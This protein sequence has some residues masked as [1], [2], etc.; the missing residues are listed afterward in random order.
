MQNKVVIGCLY[1]TIHG[2]F[3]S[4]VL[5]LVCSTAW[6][7]TLQGTAM[8]RERIALPPDAVFEAELQ[9]VSRAGAPAV[10]LGRYTL[11]PAGQPPFLF[12]I[13]YDDAAVQPGHRYTVRAIVKHQE[14]LLFTTDTHYP[15]LDGGNK[16]LQ[17]LLVS[18]RSGAKAK[19]VPGGLGSLPASYEGKLPGASNPIA[20]HVDLMP[21]GRYQLRTTHV[22]RPEPNRFDDIGRWMLE[23]DTGRI[24]LRGGREAPVFLLPVDGGSGLRKLDHDGKPIESKHNDLLT[25]LPNFAPIEPRLAVAGMFRYM[26]DAATITLC[27][28]GQR[29][30]VAMEGD[31][32]ALEAAYRQSGTEPGQPLLA[33]IDGQIAQRPSMEESQPPRATLVVERFINVW[34]RET[35]GTPLADSALRGTY[36]KLVR[37]GDSPVASP[38][39]QREAHLI[40]AND[41]LAVAGSGGCNRLNGSF[42]LDDNRLRFGRMATTMMACPDGMEQERHFLDTLGQVEGYRIRGSH[43]ELLDASGEPTARFEAVALK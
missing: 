35:C 33:S 13:A 43:L 28:N 26:A 21:E 24:V 32:K 17:L 22:G 27:V 25:R 31:Y 36:W 41:S 5:W 1:P 19:P 23:H 2:L 6:A 20:W 29:I 40:L 34:P 37:L 12:E 30:P 14:R 11:D 10:V 7:G 42:E 18:A 3:A 9:D 16:S 15:V 38:A 8:Y 4:C 39:N